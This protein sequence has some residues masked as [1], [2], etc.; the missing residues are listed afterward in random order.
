[1]QAEGRNRARWFEVD[2]KEVTQ[3]KAAIIA[4]NEDLYER[5]GPDVREHVHPGA[6]ISQ[7]KGTVHSARGLIRAI[8]VR[9]YLDEQAWELSSSCPCVDVIMTDFS[10][11]CRH[12][13]VCMHASMCLHVLRR[14]GQN[15]DRKPGGPAGGS[16]GCE[17][18][19]GRPPCSRF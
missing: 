17:R 15:P 9:R 4:A 7:I 19:G 3:R 18:P 6:S 1:M 12:Q 5:L 2:F 8:S 13:R 16:E 11:A 14:R 10:V